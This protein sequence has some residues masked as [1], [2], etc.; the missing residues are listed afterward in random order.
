MS[1]H[2]PILLFL[3][4]VLSAGAILS[5]PAPLHDELQTSN[6][7]RQ[8]SQPAAD[9][10]LVLNLPFHA[11][12]RDESVWRHPVIEHQAKYGPDRFGQPDGAFRGV[13]AEA[14][15]EIPPASALDLPGSMTLSLWMKQEEAL[16][17]NTFLTL[18][19]RSSSTEYASFSCVV[20]GASIGF[21]VGNKDNLPLFNISHIHIV[22]AQKWYHVAVCIDI[23]NQGHRIYIDGQVR[24][25][26][27]MKLDRL[28]Q[29]DLPI[30]IGA[31]VVMG[32]PAD[33]WKGWIDDVRLYN[34]ALRADEIQTLTAGYAFP[35]PA[36]AYEKTDHLGPGRYIITPVNAGDT[37][38]WPPRLYVVLAKEPV[39]KKS[40]FIFL[41]VAA[42]AAFSLLGA[43][44]FYRQRQ[45][46]QALEFEKIR[47][48]EAERFRIAREMHEDIG[49]GLS[50]LNL[51][52]DMA[53]HKNL[54][55]GLAAEIEH[56]ANASHKVSARIREIVWAIDLRHD[57]LEHLIIYFQQYATDFFH[58]S[59]VE[60]NLALPLRMPATM[61]P[62][63]TR[64][65][66]FLAFKEALHNILK[67]AHA[68]RVD[69]DFALTGK[70]LEIRIR[71]NGRGF[72]PAALG[73]AGNGL[74]NM[75]KR[76]E[77]I[78][79]VFSIRSGGEKGTEVVF[80]VEF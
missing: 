62:G 49:T 18:I 40:W 55:P 24:D 10:T 68:T 17:A 43:W 11:G 34:R 74:V 80:Q 16:P 12:A 36:S 64:R 70:R 37:L 9:S 76:M 50:A 28:V 32:L 35:S 48:L 41:I 57:S 66:V 47:T 1:A 59:G 63:N 73:D 79:G 58:H 45:L 23:E 52:T 21:T 25:T 6:V 54:E 53:L 2:A 71:D 27:K 65:M 7:K 69:I 8:T 30:I 39:W 51:L 29:A 75:K 14:F 61:L 72:D 46:E 15:L 19:S 31:K 42:A 3:L 13:G 60:L 77:D 26:I 56:I 5:Q 4:S 33:L 20:S 44:F 78:G 38:L 67:H 22:D